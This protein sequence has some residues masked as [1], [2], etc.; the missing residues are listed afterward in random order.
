MEES[1]YM[2]NRRRE[3]ER[4]RQQKA[5]RRFL[6][7]LLI[8]IALLAAAVYVFLFK[9]HEVDLGLPYDRTDTVFGMQQVSV[10]FN[11][12]TG[13][14]AD[15]CVA[16]SDIGTESLTLE[17][18]SAGL[19]DEDAQEVLYAKGIHER[20]YPASLTKVMTCLVA[21]K[22]GNLEDQV[23]VGAECLD[24]EYGSSVCDIH[25][26]DQ[27]SL[28]ELLYGLMIN[29][30]NDA[31]MTI[32]LHVGGSIDAFISMMN[33]EAERIGA[34]QTH[35]MNPH[36]LQDEDHYTTVYDMYLIFREAL[37]YPEFQDIISRTNYYITIPNT[38]GTSRDITWE[39]TN[40][41]FL[42]YAAAPKDVQVSG[43]KT[44]TT[45]EAGACLCLYTKDKYGSPFISIIL[46][47]STK[48]QLYTEMNELLSKINN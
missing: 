41:Y 34:T 27:L 19:F 14:A 11:T 4:I 39:S 6:I 29:S 36:G 45:D 23:T 7:L 21:L 47:S 18:A 3:Q 42:G 48:D 16:N 1:R 20:R 25:P 10:E 9:D 15:L 17:S 28:Q 38:D 32:A 12:A 46:K 26:G 37:Q 43:G 30:G 22:Y 44:G 35:F 2:R 33:Q 31:A 5:V 24:I 40:Y 13:F 8:L